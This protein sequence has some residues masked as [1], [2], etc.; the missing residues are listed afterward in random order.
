MTALAYGRAG[1]RLRLSKVTTPFAEFDARRF[2]DLTR[3][4]MFE[5]VTKV[6]NRRDVETVAG[7][8]LA[9]HAQP[10]IDP[11]VLVY[12][13][14]NMVA[15][16]F[17]GRFKVPP[18]PESFATAALTLGSQNAELVKLYFDIYAAI[19]RY[20]KEVTRALALDYVARA[21]SLCDRIDPARHHDWHRRFDTLDGILDI[22]GLT[23]AE[24]QTSGSP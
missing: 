9:G 22:S 5:A 13:G 14:W 3:V 20:D 2:R 7:A 6:L 16:A 8:K 21:P 4:R 15:D 19:F 23:Q 11:R 17:M 10:D 1:G 24:E 18:S 12:A